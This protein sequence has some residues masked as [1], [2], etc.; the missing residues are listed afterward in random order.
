[1]KWK[2]TFRQEQRTCCPP[3]KHWVVRTET[4]E[5]ADAEQAQQIV[6]DGWK[7]NHKIEIKTVKE[8]TDGNETTQG[9]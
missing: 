6:I 4:V 1:M 2:V 3:R 5:A 7:Y 9:Q 8:I